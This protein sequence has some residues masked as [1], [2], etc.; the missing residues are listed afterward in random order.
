VLKVCWKRPNS[1]IRRF[2]RRIVECHG[3]QNGSAARVSA[4]ELVYAPASRERTRLTPTTIFLSRLYPLLL[5]EYL[6]HTPSY[7]RTSVYSH[8]IADSTNHPPE[9]RLF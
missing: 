6:R 4:G 9:P 3:Y 8:P 5:Q 7:T 1:A 2:G